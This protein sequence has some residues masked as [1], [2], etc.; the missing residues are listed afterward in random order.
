MLRTSSAAGS[1]AYSFPTKAFYQNEIQISLAGQTVYEPLLTGFRNGQVRSI[2]L[3]VTKDSDVAPAT[4]APFAKNF[5]KYYLPHDVQLLYNGTVYYRADASS[6]EFWNLVSTE[7]PSLV[8]SPVLSAAGA[9][10]PIVATPNISKWV[11]IPFSQ[12]FE[13]LSGSHMYVSG[14][15]IQNAVVNL[16]LTLPDTA[17]YTL[18]AMYAYN[19]VLMCQ[20]G[21]AE[22]V[23]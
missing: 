18:H 20:G 13:Q 12:V 7:T 21:S 16:K 14:M 3:W 5:T 10:N 17:A 8:D 22:Y 6:S 2:I 4:N 15:N 9:G 1:K 23:F 11:E 19:C